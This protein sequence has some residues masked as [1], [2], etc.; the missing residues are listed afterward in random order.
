MK[1][2]INGMTKLVNPINKTKNWRVI[3]RPIKYTKLWQS[4]FRKKKKSR[5]KQTE[6]DLKLYL[7]TKNLKI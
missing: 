1:A 5:T 2:E 7:H 6:K 3:L 4:Q